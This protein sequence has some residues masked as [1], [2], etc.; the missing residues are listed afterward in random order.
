MRGSVL[1]PEEQRLVGCVR[2]KGAPA[3]ESFAWMDL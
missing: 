1:R 3:Q 2:S